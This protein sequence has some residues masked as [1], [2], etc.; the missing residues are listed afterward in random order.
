MEVQGEDGP[1]Q[2]SG[3]ESLHALRIL[4]PAPLDLPH[5]LAVNTCWG[6]SSPGSVGRIS[7]RGE[8]GGDVLPGI[9]LAEPHRAGAATDVEISP[10]GLL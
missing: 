5:R 1:G 3:D 7:L 9:L 2:S 6:R 10:L 8:P 4:D